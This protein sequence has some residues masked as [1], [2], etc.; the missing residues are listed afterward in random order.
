MI[1]GEI[2]APFNMKD[3]GTL[4]HYI[5]LQIVQYENYGVINFQGYLS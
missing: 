3:L 2:S 1:K 4:T 5:R